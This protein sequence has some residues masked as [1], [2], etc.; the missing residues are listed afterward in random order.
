[1]S[2]VAALDGLVERLAAQQR[3]QSATGYTR[4]ASAPPTPFVEYTLSIEL[5]RCEDRAAATPIS[6]ASS[7]T[8]VLLWLYLSPQTPSQ[9][10]ERISRWT[11]E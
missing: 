8:K 9:G 3:A 11:C 10:C 2:A 7:T 1:M 6:K 4:F 5:P